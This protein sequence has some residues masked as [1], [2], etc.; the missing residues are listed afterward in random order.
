MKSETSRDGFNFKHQMDS[1]LFTNDISKPEY[2]YSV[3][4][5]QKR[6]EASL[7]MPKR[8]IAV[9]AKY[10]YP[11]KFY[12]NYQ[13]N[14]AFFIDKNKPQMKSELGF[15]GD[16]AHVGRVM[17]ATGKLTFTHPRVKTLGINGEFNL[18]ADQMAMDSNVEFDI[19]TNP[20]DKIVFTG[21]FGN[22][23]TSGKGFN[24]TNDVEVYS[25]GLDWKL[26]F[27]EH[28]G[29]SFERRLVTYGSEVTLPLN[30]WR[31]GVHAFASEKNFEVIGVIFN[32]EVLK[33]NAVYDME[34][35][36]LAL[37]SSLK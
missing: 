4:V 7:K 26:K 27:H 17:K 20:M 2:R 9:E 8:E 23:D 30:D 29:L 35:H 18:D 24:I 14:V 11:E 28:T 33:A 34:K 1:S 32:E 12:G 37:E 5:D 13:T 3:Y 10:N 21:K 22:S 25:K 31:F 15:N 19:F 36:D 16:V 6:A